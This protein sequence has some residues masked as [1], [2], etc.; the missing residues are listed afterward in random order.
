V[1]VRVRE[2]DNR[3]RIN[4]SLRGVPQGGDDSASN[5]PEVILPIGEG[6]PIE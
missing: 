5:G 2:I 4:L 3:G 1:T 6:A